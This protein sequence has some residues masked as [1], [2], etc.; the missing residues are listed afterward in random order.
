VTATAVV[1]IAA[2]GTAAA[3]VPDAEAATTSSLVS[4]P[5][6]D[7]HVIFQDFSFFQPYE[8]NTYTTLTE[9]ASA[10]KDLGITDVWMA[11]PYR[12]LNAYNEEGYAVTDRYDLGEF[13][14]GHNQS[15][16]TKYGTSAELKTAITALHDAG[17]NV[18]ADIVP[19][20]MYLYQDREVVRVTAVNQY[21]NLDTSKVD[22]KLYEV[23]TVGGGEGQKKYG[24]INTWKS[25]NLN[26]IS[27]QD[28]G[29]DRVMLDADGKPYRY[30]GGDR[31]DNYVPTGMQTAANINNID[32]YLTVDGY[33]I[34]GKTATGGDIWRPNLMY[35][36]EHQQG[37]ITIRYLDY[38][39]AHPPVGSGVTASDT[40][41]QVRAKLIQATDAAVSNTT[42]DY[43]GSQPGYNS[44][45]ERGIIALRFDN[46]DV[47]HVNQNVLQYEYLIGQDVDNTSATVQSEQRNWEEFLLDEY[48]FD[49]FRWDAAGHYNKKILQNAGQLVAD[50]LAASGENAND[51]LNYIESYVDD[52]VAFEN[53]NGN[54]QLA[55]DDDPYYAYLDALGDGTPSKPLSTTIT[56]SLVDRVNPSGTVTPNWSFVNNHDQEHNVMATIP[57][58]DVQTGG[59]SY[60]TKQ[61]QLAQYKLYSADRKR[62]AK[63]Y[64]P[65]NVPAAYALELTNKD[66][67]P[68]VFYGDMWEATDSYM[69]T[70]S[71]YYEA[72]NDLLQVRETN[73]SGD[74]VVSS[75][76]SNLSSTAGQNLISSVREGTDRTSGMGVVIGNTP[77]LDTTIEVPMGAAHA[78]QEYVDAMGYH[79]E[80]LTT[81]GN[82]M[83]T[84][85][86]Q[87]TSNVTVNGYLGVWV[88]RTA[89]GEPTGT[90]SPAPETGTPLPPVTPVATTGPAATTTRLLVADRS[91]SFGES[92]TLAASVDLGATGTIRFM[93]G[94]TALAT[95]NVEDG[96][97]VL[98]TA[99]KLAVGT[100]RITAEYSG[101]STHAASVSAASTLTVAK[102]TTKLAVTK[103]RTTPSGKTKLS[104][105]ATELADSDA[106]TGKVRVLVGKKAVQTVRLTAKK[107]GTVTVTLPKKYSG[108][109]TVRA[110]YLGSSDVASATSPKVKVSA[111]VR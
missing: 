47:N 98:D 91:V 84:V 111:R 19:N 16:A 50:R 106:V 1:A 108:A 75:Y 38:V 41:D 76:A 99:A 65:N 6:L 15:T 73:A 105:T 62:V 87:G 56:S 72:I 23:Y 8:S 70:E 95:A 48:D 10:L 92:A 32:G 59:A 17:L 35:Y 63:Q 58:T 20:Q 83:L 22:N 13:P 26:G 43:I 107:H 12:A 64:A 18:Q 81:D 34:A 4:G 9:R 28:L 74:Q 37:A 33:F 109:F 66:T 11:P 51:N 46:N 5:D 25:A 110:K 27:P 103:V 44:T 89:S 31:T 69:Q 78:N 82:G 101:D 30:L 24:E 14:A 86:V 97:V 77:D 55:Y 49:G 57:V 21:G 104:V 96:L 85:A 2:T 52:Q 68:T 67:V 79:D 90:P 40:D 7:S 94:A 3:P 60:G 71:P 93:D 102:A 100:H 61:Y 88:P 29:T 45:S 36:V 42:N 54:P 80:T 53:E 39:R